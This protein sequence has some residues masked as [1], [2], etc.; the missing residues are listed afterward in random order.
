MTERWGPRT[1]GLAKL[2]GHLRVAQ[3]PPSAPALGGWERGPRLPAAGW[4]P[5]PSL[6]FPARKA[7]SGGR[8]G[9]P[10]TS[11]LRHPRGWI[12]AAPEPRGVGGTWD[13][14]TA[15]PGPA[16]GPEPR[17]RGP[18]PHPRGS[19]R[20]AARGPEPARRVDCPE[21]AAGAP[22]GEGHGAGRGD[23]GCR[24]G[25]GA[26][27]GSLPDGAGGGS[28]GA[29]CRCGGAGCAR[30]ERA[31]A[32]G[33]GDPGAGTR[34]PCTPGILGDPARS[35]PFPPPRPRS[36]SPPP[37]RPLACVAVTPILSAAGPHAQSLPLHPPAFRVAEAGK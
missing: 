20:G 13:L 35:D 3:S 16:P 12:A 26:G 24:E 31:G 17:P 15:A 11:R 5:P 27:V 14:A 28:G 4:P 30:G 2:H 19:G 21:S 25:R 33:V 34:A 18:A 1:Q 36:R 8:A 9:L 6:S 22:R 23:R 37:A 32:L 10:H 29:I 7:E